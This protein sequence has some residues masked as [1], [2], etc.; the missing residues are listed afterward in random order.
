MI[1][2]KQLTDKDIG[3][4]VKYT[5]N[6]GEEAFGRIKSWGDIRINAFVFVI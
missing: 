3:R 2:I 4:W 1:D 5:G 6:A